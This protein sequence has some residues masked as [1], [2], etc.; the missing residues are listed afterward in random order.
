M[1]EKAWVVPFDD[2]SLGIAY[3]KTGGLEGFMRLG[4]SGHPDLPALMQL[5][6]DE[7]LET[8]HRKINNVIPFARP[9]G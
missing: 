8:L 1:Y 7:D 2:Q 3:K 9:G 4:K 5:L 6:S